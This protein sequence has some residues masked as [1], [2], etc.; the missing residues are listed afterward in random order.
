MK[1]KKNTNS[2]PLVFIDD[3][4][5]AS[6]FDLLE[7]MQLRSQKIL[8]VSDEKIWQ[9]NHQF[10]L[11]K[12]SQEKSADISSKSQ[13]TK[14]QCEKFLKNFAKTLF[15]KNLEACESSYKT[16]IFAA[17][18]CGAEMILAF[19][20][21]TVNDLC[22]YAAAKINIPYVIIPSAAS[23]NGYLSTNASITI[24]GHKQSL[25]AK[26]PIAVICDLGIILN[27]PIRMTRSGIADLMCFW[28][29]WFDWTL[30]SR[31][32]G[33]EFCF[34]TFEILQKK[35]EF[36][37]KN[38]HEF[39]LKNRDFL[40]FLMEVLF[41][42]GQ[43]M[44]IAK[45]SKPASQSEHLI[46]H[47]LTMKFPQETKKFLHGELIAITTMTSLSLQNR[48][49]K[50]LKN[51]DKTSK[52]KFYQTISQNFYNKKTSL[53]LSF[54][55]LNEQATKHCEEEF[56]AKLKVVKNA[57]EAAKNENLEGNNEDKEF[58]IWLRQLCFELK[59]IKFSGSK[60]AKIFHHFQINYDSSKLGISKFQYRKSVQNARFIRNRITCLDFFRHR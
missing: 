17:K 16:I 15:L 1:S 19:G 24:E 58:E 47:Y 18:E 54:L 37:S 35:M 41:L 28:S 21:G 5:A 6:F 7:K 11:S 3:N 48:I 56:K 34:E 45:S 57:V 52:F 40:K 2:K 27:S 50:T 20:S 46:A 55:G 8:L 38:F 60:L 44:T 32:F 12:K 39:Q 36:L 51:F 31:L 4:L 59:K 30:A 49:F 22:K 25:L 53:D 43:A 26:P 14:T 33:D 23:M 42:S 10:F 9:K 13:K 29:C